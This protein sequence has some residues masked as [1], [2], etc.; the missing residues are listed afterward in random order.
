MTAAITLT[1]PAIKAIHTSAIGLRAALS[2]SAA[3]AAE[4][5]L[6]EALFTGMMIGALEPESMIV[7]DPKLIDEPSPGTEGEG[8]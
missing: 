3:S 4:E 7:C 5:A 6:D 1:V 8:V 2:C